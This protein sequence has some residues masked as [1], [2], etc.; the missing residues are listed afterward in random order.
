MDGNGRDNNFRWDVWWLVRWVL[1]RMH[2]PGPGVKWV[3]VSSKA[4]LDEYWEEPTQQAALVTREKKLKRI[5][6]FFS[7][8]DPIPKGWNLMNEL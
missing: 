8:A 5:D 4:N 3:K 7:A 2:R 1:I 6:A